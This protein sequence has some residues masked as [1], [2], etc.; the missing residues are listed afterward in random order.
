MRRLSPSAMEIGMTRTLQVIEMITVAQERREPIYSTW[1]V[2]LMTRQDGMPILE[3][4]EQL[5]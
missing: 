1:M 4:I 5:S 3:S 2:N